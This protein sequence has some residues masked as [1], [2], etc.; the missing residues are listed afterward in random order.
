[1]RITLLPANE[2][3]R[4]RWKNGLGWTREILRVPQDSSEWDWRASIAEVDQGGPFSIF[5]GCE[6]ELVLLTGNGMR[7]NFDD[8]DSV[9]L[10]PPHGKHPFSGER[11]L[12]A[13]LT[14]GP[15]T[16]FN[17][18]WRRDRI[19]TQLLH[20]PLVGPMMFFAE[21]DVSW[22]VHLLSGQAQIKD[23]ARASALA[24]G[25]SAWLQP[26]SGGGHR[27]VLDGGG[28]VLLAKIETR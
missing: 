4:V 20:R 7:L 26:S 22:F 24:T 3:T 19:A 1:M 15:T 9:E 8:G 13:E 17:L 23:E 6:R 14:A 12:S 11:P 2:Y 28:E 21:A 25:D 27:L 5:E 16:D 10:L 18:I